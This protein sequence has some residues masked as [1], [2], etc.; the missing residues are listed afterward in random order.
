MYR[1]VTKPEALYHYCSLETFCNIIKNKSI[2]LSDFR[3]TNDAKEVIWAKEIVEREV[4]PGIQEKINAEIREKNENGGYSG[5]EVANALLNHAELGVSYWGFCLSKKRDDLGQW[6]GYGDDGA[7]ISIGFKKDKLNEIIQLKTNEKPKDDLTSDKETDTNSSKAD[8]I[9]VPVTYK[10]DKKMFKIIKREAKEFVK[11]NKEICQS[12][13]R[14]LKDLGLSGIS[15]SPEVAEKIVME[16]FAMKNG[17]FYKM[18]A[19][20]EEK[21]YR[22]IFSASQEKIPE[23]KLNKETLAALE[24]PCGLLF[25]DYEYTVRD[26]MLVSHLDIGFKNLSDV[27]ASVT[28]GPKSKATKEDIA[29]FLKLNGVDLDLQKIE[30]S[31]ASYR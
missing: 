19:F 17:P 20:H 5:W 29:L 6:R 14:I 13:E 18:K 1:K 15:I 31:K 10:K 27:I 12:I 16:G 7:G 28:I 4:L 11:G 24:W 8:L 2:W 21:E 9:L 26:N 23:E 30:K 3:K 25:R 22:I